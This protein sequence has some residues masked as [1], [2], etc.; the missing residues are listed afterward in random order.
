MPSR[1]HLSRLISQSVLGEPPH[2][3]ARTRQDDYCRAQRN[4]RSIR[5]H[6]LRVAGTSIIVKQ[7]PHIIKSLHPARHPPSRSFHIDITAAGLQVVPS[8]LH[9]SAS[10]AID[11]A[12]S[13]DRSFPHSRKRLIPPYPPSTPEAQ[14]KHLV[15]RNKSDS[16][17]KPS[18]GQTQP[19]TKRHRTL[20]SAPFSPK[21]H[22]CPKPTP[23]S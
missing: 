7:R 14:G 10:R 19:N 22:L 9:C 16:T 21:L 18:S 8:T 13:P 20:Q 17:I 12:S 4:S 5:Q 6:Y 23:I 1:H 2:T 15:D 3:T 11:A